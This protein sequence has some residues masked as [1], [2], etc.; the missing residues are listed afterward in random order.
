VRWSSSCAQSAKCLGLNVEDEQ[1][2]TRGRAQASRA[3]VQR[4]L[5]EGDALA[6]GDH[7]ARCTHRAARL[8]ETAY[9][10]DLQFQRRVTAARAERGVHG[11]AARAV[12]QRRGVATIGL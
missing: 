4:G 10:R 3:I 11:D 1:R 5:G 9:I 12:E 7:A 8:A 6:D 2:R